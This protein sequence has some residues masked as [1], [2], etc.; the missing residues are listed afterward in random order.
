VYGTQQQVNGRVETA[1]VAYRH[2]ERA[3]LAHEMPSKDIT[4]TQD[5]TC[6]GGLS[7]VGRE[8][9]SNSMLLEQATRARDHDTWHEL[10]EQALAGLNGRVMQSTSDEAPGLLASVAHHLGAHGRVPEPCG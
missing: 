6:T 7:L 4:L 3:R 9:A 10:M 5:A 8:P 1:M 2:E